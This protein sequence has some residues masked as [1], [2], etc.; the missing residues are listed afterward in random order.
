MLSSEFNYFDPTKALELVLQL[1]PLL[2]EQVEGVED[3]ETALF[4]LFGAIIKLRFYEVITPDEGPVYH[5]VTEISELPVSIYVADWWDGKTIVAVN[6]GLQAT[7][8][9]ENMKNIIK[10]AVI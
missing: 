10:G 3:I 8:I 1:N 2:D 7:Y 5:Y 6:S 4:H 9:N